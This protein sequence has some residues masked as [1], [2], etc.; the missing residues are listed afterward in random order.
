MK[1]CSDEEIFLDFFLSE[2]Q[3][4]FKSEVSEFLSYGLVLELLHH[5]GG[6]TQIWLWL[7]GAER[8]F[9]FFDIICNRAP[10]NL[11]GLSFENFENVD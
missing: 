11:K 3:E 10:F 4:N 6:S 9:D 2:F 8:E 7:T 1:F 5:P